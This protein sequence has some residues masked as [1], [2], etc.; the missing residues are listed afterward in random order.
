[1]ES[2]QT[3][4]GSRDAFIFNG[5]HEFLSYDS[6][7]V[8]V[9]TQKYARSFK[10]SSSRFPLISVLPIFDFKNRALADQLVEAVVLLRWPQRMRWLF[11]CRT[12]K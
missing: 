1:M 12:S 8:G 5:S 10:I 11:H 3:P 7:T 4:S 9:V 2:K 6:A